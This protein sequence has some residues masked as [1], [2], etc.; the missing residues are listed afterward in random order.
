MALRGQ[1][2]ICSRYDTLTVE[3]VRWSAKTT[4]IAFSAMNIAFSAMSLI[5]AL[6]G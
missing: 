3:V 2:D 4:D 6:E 1:S 5:G